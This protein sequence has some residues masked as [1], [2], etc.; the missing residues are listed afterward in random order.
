MDSTTLYDF[1]VEITSFVQSQVQ[2]QPRLFELF[3][4]IWNVLSATDHQADDIIDRLLTA[5]WHQESA[6]SIASVF[7]EM[8]LSSLQLNKMCKRIIK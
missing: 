2:V 8:E 3:S 6:I 4:K 7:N 1:A 5:T